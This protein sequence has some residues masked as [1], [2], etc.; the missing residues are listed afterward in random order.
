MGRGL[1]PDQ[2][3]L[4]RTAY[5]RGAT[6]AEVGRT[7]LTVRAL[8]GADVVR[9]RRSEDPAKYNSEMVAASRS[10]DRLCRRGL[11]VPVHGRIARQ[12]RGFGYVVKPQAAL[13]IAARA[14]AALAE[15]VVVKA[16][17]ED[18]VTKPVA[19]A[20]KTPVTKPVPGK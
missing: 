20:E 1:S 2:W 18:M 15:K 11:M 7:G 16:P 14:R 12:G 9:T 6:E 3:R 17:V 19:L 8:R 5:D 13:A 4:L 10:F